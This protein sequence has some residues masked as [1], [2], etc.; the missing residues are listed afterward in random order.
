MKYEEYAGR[1]GDI[2]TGIVQQTDNRYTLLDLGKV[3]ALLPQAEQ[4][5]YERYE[6][7]A[8]LKAYI[9]EVRKTTKGPRSS[10]AVP[11][12]ASSSGSR[13]R[14]ARDR[15]RRVEIKA[16]AGGRATHQ[17]R[18]LVERPNVTRSG[19]RRRPGR[20]C[21]WSPTSCA[22]SASTSSLLRR[23]GRADSERR[24]P[25]ARARGRLDEETGTATVVV[26]G[27]S[28]RWPSARRG[29]TPAW[30]RAYRLAH[31]HQERDPAGRGRG[32][33]LRRPG[34]GRGRVGRGRERRAGLE[35]R[36]GRR[37]HVGRGVVAPG[38]GPVRLPPKSGP[39]RS[40]RGRR[41][42][43]SRS[44]SRRAAP[45][46]DGAGGGRRL[47]GR[48][49]RGRVS[50]EARHTPTR[51]CVGCRRALPAD[52]LIRIVRLPGGALSP[53]RN[54]AGRGAWL[55][56]GSWGCLDDAVR[57]HGFERAFTA[58]VE[59]GDLQQLRMHLGE[60]W[61]SPAPDVRG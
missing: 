36:R 53:D 4:V 60:A 55:C 29:R 17:D 59:A 50:E 44:P 49:P 57:R 48:Q 47:G 37:G 34:L 43:S 14:G 23:P 22:A 51:T 20:G 24:G 1:E 12:P 45:A 21:A 5:S 41:R 19:L 32:R 8:R 30:R 13:A 39:A 26:S 31:R 33:R 16:A 46:A 6:H 54:G 25:G 2:V 40:A 61:G 7:G 42:S 15:L 52:Q 27:S 28:S 10:S 58:P 35:A 9:V 56:R 18:R 11:T 38:G 3:E